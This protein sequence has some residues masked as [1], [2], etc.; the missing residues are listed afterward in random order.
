MI[1]SCLYHIYPI[2]QPRPP[3]IKK[4]NKKD[5]SKS[6]MGSKFD[7]QISLENCCRQNRIC[8]QIR[9]SWYLEP[10]SQRQ[11]LLLSA[12]VNS[13]AYIHKNTQSHL[14]KICENHGISLF[15]F[16]ML[17]GSYSLEG[18]PAFFRV[19]YPT[20]TADIF[21]VREMLEKIE[22]HPWFF[23]SFLSSILNNMQT[24]GWRDFLD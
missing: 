12:F 15:K 11:Y 14:A 22:K 23:L 13:V 24:Q 9:W 5:H 7:P 18:T 8:S 17:F 3:E 21:K 10:I 6:F 19:F 20:S 16:M 1:V 2:Y 4:G